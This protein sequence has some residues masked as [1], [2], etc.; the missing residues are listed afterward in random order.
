MPYADPETRRD[1]QR[2]YKKKWRAKQTK[3]HPLQGFKVYICPR[4]PFF[5]LR[6]E[7]FNNGFLITDKPEVQAEVERHHEFGK[8]IFPIALDL[9]GPSVEDE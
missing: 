8:F 7:Q 9:S 5:R 2:R 1:F 4:F 6:W 3:I